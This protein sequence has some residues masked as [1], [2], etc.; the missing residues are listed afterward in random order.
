MPR[1]TFDKLGGF[2]DQ[3][4]LGGGDIAFVY[5]LSRRW[6]HIN[7]RAKNPNDAHFATTPVYVAYKERG[8]NLNL[9]V[10]YLEDVICRHFWH[11]AALNRQYTKR[12]QYC[13]LAHGEDFPV[14]YRDDGLLMWTKPEC[15]TQLK[16]YFLSRLEDG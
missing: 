5:C 2:Y 7:L 14:T 11:G 15:S 6:R 3:N 4:I 12:G 9:R 8:V 13:P 16:S 10:G 1:T